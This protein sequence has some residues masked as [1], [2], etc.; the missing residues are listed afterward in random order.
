VE[1]RPDVP[2]GDLVREDE[3]K[4]ME[5]FSKVASEYADG[6]PRGPDAPFVADAFVTL[7]AITGAAY[8]MR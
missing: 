7:G 2:D 4:A 3:K 6:N 8:R 1:A 5:L